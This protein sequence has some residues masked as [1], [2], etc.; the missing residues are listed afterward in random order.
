MQINRQQIIF[1][2]KH[3]IERLGDIRFA[4]QVVFVIIVLLISWSG[5][6][7][8]QTNYGLQRQISGLRQQADVQKLEN[9]NLAL[10]NEYFK[11]HQYLE[12]SARQNFGLANNGEKVLI[13]PKEVAL[14]NTI[15][16]PGLS[17][18]TTTQKSSP[19]HHFQ[20]WVD[21]FLHKQD[22]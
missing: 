22:N 21:F 18:E 19:Q 20:S 9:T 7:T 1:H 6:K 12:L 10:Q 5:I 15:D 16:T 11:S 2:T 13:V 14:A 8:I 4:G 17:D 3:F